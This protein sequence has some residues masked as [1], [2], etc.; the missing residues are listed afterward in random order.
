MNKIKRKILVVED[1]KLFM[2]LYARLLKDSGYE[3]ISSTNAY[4]AVEEIAK[5]NI[6]DAIILDLFLPGV[7]GLALIHELQSYDDTRKIPVILCT[8]SADGITENTL[9]EY[10]I[11]KLIDKTT[12]EP[13][14][15]IYTI[16]GIFDE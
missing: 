9:K 13:K 15:L 10:G 11:A 16:R 4:D 12:M 2:H 8:S 1:D 3:I 14:D 5:G 7:N 6:P